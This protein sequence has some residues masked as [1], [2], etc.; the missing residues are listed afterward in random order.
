MDAVPAL[1]L[2]VSALALAVSAWSASYTRRDT[3]RVSYSSVVE[4][5]DDV[6]PARRQLR[7]WIRATY[8]TFDADDPATHPTPATIRADLA[9]S[10]DATDAVD[11]IC[12]AFDLVGFLDRRGLIEQYIVDEMYAAALMGLWDPWLAAYVEQPSQSGRG[13]EHL[14]ELRQ[15]VARVA[16]VPQRHPARTGRTEWP[17][18]PRAR[19]K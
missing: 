14:W 19:E 12:R 15:L 4:L 9:T 17:R 10:P 6:R 7:E 13:L 16:S 5:L 1:S 8:P 11:R 3:R 18:D 2:G